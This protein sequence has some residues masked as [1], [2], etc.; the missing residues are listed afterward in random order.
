M[1]VMMA[2]FVVVVVVMVVMRSLLRFLTVMMLNFVNPRGRGRYRVE[3][4]AAGVDE[5]VEVHVAVVTF[6]DFCLWLQRAND[7]L[8]ACQL[9]RLHLGG[10][11]EQDDVAE[12]DLLDNEVLDVFLADFLPHERVAASEFVSHSQRIDYGCDAVESENAS[13]MY[14]GPMVGMEQT[15]WAMGAGSQMPLASMTM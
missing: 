1:V 8:D 14:S 2:R 11:V 3:I 5:L 6:D 4:E 15:V 7:V 12:L 9:A 13:L 10:L